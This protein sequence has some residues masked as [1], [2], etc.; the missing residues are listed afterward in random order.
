MLA[1]IYEIMTFNKISLEDLIEFIDTKQETF[2]A[3]QYTYNKDKKW[4]DEAIELDELEE[5]SKFV[6]KPATSQKP[7]PKKSKAKKNKAKKSKAKAAVEE[8]TKQVDD[9]PVKSDSPE[10]LNEPSPV[11]S[12]TSEETNTLPWMSAVKKPAT[13]QPTVIKTAFK[14]QQ[15][16]KQPTK[17]VEEEDKRFV[18]YTVQEFI[19]CIKEKQKLHVDYTID[20][21]S[22]CEHTF[23]GTVCRDVKECGKI[24]VQR[25]INNLDC[26]YKFCQF[27]HA[28]EMADQEAMDNYMDTM[29]EYNRIKKSKQV[30]V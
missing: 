21:D 25:C 26:K 5:L 30:Y 9:E 12:S 2:N 28:D 24:H 8:A 27:L 16:A 19:Q 29:P 1:T 20:P 22:H 23:N 6:A 14:Q 7:S 4:G 18:I 3:P 11:E 17:E 15:E 10:S 13:M